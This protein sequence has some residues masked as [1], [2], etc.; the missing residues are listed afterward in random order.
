MVSISPPWIVRLLV[1]VALSRAAAQ[2]NRCRPHFVKLAPQ[3]PHFIGPQQMAR[4]LELPEVLPLAIRP[5]LTGHLSLPGL[6]RLPQL[7]RNDAQRGNLL[8]DPRLRAIQPRPALAGRS[9]LHVAEPV[10]D[11]LADVELVVEDA[12][13]SAEVAV[14]RGRAPVPRKGRRSL[15]VERF[16]DLPRRY[17]LAIREKMRRTTLASATLMRRPPASIAHRNSS[18]RHHIH[19]PRHRRPAGLHTPA[20]AARACRQGPSETAHSSFPSGRREAR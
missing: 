1:Q 14:D 15:A 19:R 7:L 10:P 12:G 16:G 20:Q 18:G 3:A 4:T 17:A 2:P 8:D 11:E 6:H 13:S 5:R 9:D